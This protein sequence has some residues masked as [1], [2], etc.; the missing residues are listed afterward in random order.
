MKKLFITLTLLLTFR[1][2]AAFSDELNIVLSD[3]AP[4]AFLE[5]KEFKG[6]NVEVL[7][8]IEKI[9]GLKFNYYLFPHIRILNQQE[10][11]LMDLFIIHHKTCKGLGSD[12]EVQQ[13]LYNLPPAILILKHVIPDQKMRI[14][15]LAGTCT[16]LMSKHL[17]PE[18]IININNFEQA[19]EMIKQHRLE[20]VCGLNPVIR[21]YLKNDFVVYKSEEHSQDYQAVIC[22]K[23]NLSPALKDKLDRAGKKIKVSTHFLN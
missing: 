3:V 23:V 5:N 15:R 6:Y 10:K 14:G 16:E 22:R 11:A 13:K 19:V 7:R 1:A 8:D 20:G 9:S 21:H 12:F 18:Q 4:F 2:E 17:R